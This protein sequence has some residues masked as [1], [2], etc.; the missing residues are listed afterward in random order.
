MVVWHV[1]IK[2]TMRFIVYNGRMANAVPYALKRA[3]ELERIIR[4]IQE[5]GVST[6][7]LSSGT[8]SKSYTHLDLN[9]LIAERN[10]MLHAYTCSS[11]PGGICFQKPH[12]GGC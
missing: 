11:M 7:S 8:G 2:F 1:D 10:R 4:E 3:R 12:F 5:S 9:S 6:A